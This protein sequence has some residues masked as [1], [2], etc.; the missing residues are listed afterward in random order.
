MKLLIAFCILLIS[1]VAF[2]ATIENVY[3]HKNTI[4]DDFGTCIY[5]K[6]QRQMY[7]RTGY[8][9]FSTL[10]VGPDFRFLEIDGDL[11]IDYTR[12]RYYVS[13]KEMPSGAIVRYF[14]DFETADG[15]TWDVAYETPDELRIIGMRS[16]QIN[17]NVIVSKETGENIESELF[18]FDVEECKSVL[19]E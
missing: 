1:N 10:T 3:V 7:E 16:K 8:A 2:S 19:A 6:F 17:S 13:G 5:G 11:E 18:R 12:S 9:V 4:K 15:S 14:I